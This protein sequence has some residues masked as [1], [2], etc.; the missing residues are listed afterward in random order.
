MTYDSSIHLAYHI[1]HLSVKL[2]SAAEIAT[3]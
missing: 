1:K 2:N 3:E